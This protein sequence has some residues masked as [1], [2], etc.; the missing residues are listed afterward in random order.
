MSRSLK[1]LVLVLASAGVV[2]FPAVDA[3]ACGGKGGGGGYRVA[4]RPA[5]NYQYNY[6]TCPTQPH[7]VQR[8]IHQQ[9][10]PQQQAQFP[11]QQGQ[12]PQQQ[13]NS[14]SS[15]AQFPQQAGQ[16]PTQQ[17]S[18]AQ[19]GS[20]AAWRRSAAVR[21]AASGSAAVCPATSCAGSKSPGGRFRCK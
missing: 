14:R 21:P 15:P 12:F 13:G 3:Q 5:Y 11:Q 7:V 8:P 20:P 19:Q 2:I 10:F 9:P 18:F 16:F 17:A 1:S 4:Y 6:A